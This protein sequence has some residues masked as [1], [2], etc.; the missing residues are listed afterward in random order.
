VNQELRKKNVAHSCANTAAR[1]SISMV[2][3]CHYPD[4]YC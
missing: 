3:Y 4:V 1:H 2:K